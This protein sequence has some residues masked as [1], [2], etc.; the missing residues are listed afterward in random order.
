MTAF[1][2]I[3]LIVIAAP[4]ALELRRRRMTENARA[5]ATGRFARLPQG[6]TH[7]EWFGPSTG[8]VLILIHGLTTPSFVWRGMTRALAA[9][10][11]RV[12]T[13]DL[14]GRGY[15]DR[16]KGRQDGAFFIKQLND[17]L[18]HEHIKND[19]TVVGYSMGG[20]IAT[21]FASADPDRIRQLVLL[22][23]AGML[24]ISGGMAGFIRDVPGIGDWLMRALYPSILRK[25]IRAERALKSS[26]TGISELQLSE[27]NFRG[28]V[29]SVLSSLRGVLAQ[30]LMKEHRSLG[31]QGIRV[32]AIWGE[33][34]ELIPV[35]V[36]ATLAEWNHDANQEVIEGAGHG[37][38]YTHSE[39]VIDTMRGWMKPAPAFR[40]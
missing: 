13:Y 27:L 38:P 28:F 22:A 29:P 24:Q 10:G 15:S 2:A 34:D 7:Y 21:C 25:G 17:L 20:A 11:Y 9:S 40:R 26:V 6:V 39:Q 23:P 36:V 18:A 30:P 12:L 32:L 35:K 16:P 4:F 14:Y 33:K 8:P 37:L 31:A 5:P 3:L 19:L 1:I